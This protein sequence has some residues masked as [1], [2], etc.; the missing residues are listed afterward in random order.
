MAIEIEDLSMADLLL[1]RQHYRFSSS[2]PP[3]VSCSAMTKVLVI[4]DE[5]CHGSSDVSERQREDSLES[6]PQMDPDRHASNI[7]PS[8]ISESLETKWQTVLRLYLIGFM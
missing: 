6:R 1:L 4:Y 5:Y 7:W 2:S 3:L 8:S